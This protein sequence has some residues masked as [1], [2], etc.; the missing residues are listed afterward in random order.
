MDFESHGTHVAGTI[1]AVGN[2]GGGLPG[3]NWNVRI[4]P[5]QMCSPNPLVGCNT[6]AAADAF[7]YAGQ[8][9]MRW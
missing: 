5:L 4:A 8:K 7:V 9:G 1:G 2:N 3:V 6:A